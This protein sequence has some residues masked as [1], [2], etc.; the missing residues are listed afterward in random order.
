M[1]RPEGQTGKPFCRL[2]ES[3]WTVLLEVLSISEIFKTGF[4]G[5]NEGKQRREKGICKP[6]GE[7]FRNS[8]KPC[9]HFVGLIS[10]MTDILMIVPIV[11][12][13]AQGQ[14]LGK[15]DE[16]ERV[17]KLLR[18]GV[19]FPTASGTAVLPEE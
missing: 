9:S 16:Q 13:P 3:L 6:F 10:S 1:G 18:S 2:I 19:R 17:R 11:P 4:S 12:G 15:E 5:H 7:S 14:V 8:V